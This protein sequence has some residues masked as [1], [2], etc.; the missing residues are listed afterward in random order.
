MIIDT[1]LTLFPVA[2]IAECIKSYNHHEAYIS[3]SSTLTDT[4]KPEKFTDK[5]KWIDW[6]PTIIN[7]LTLISGSNG[8]PLTYL[9]RTT[10][11]QSKDVYNYFIDEYVDNVPLVGHAF[12]TYAAEVH[13]YIVRFT[14]GNTFAEANMVVHAEK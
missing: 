3:K 12:T 1:D 5:M 11:V 10:K 7:L 9:C 8:A 14:T 4:G 2:N 6:D 13:T